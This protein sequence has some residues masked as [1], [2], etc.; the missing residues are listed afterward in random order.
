M[1]RTLSVV[2]QLN[3]PLSHLVPGRRNPRRVKPARE[4]HRQLVALIRSQGL[5]QPLVVR[6]MED[7]PKYYLVIAGHRRLAALKEIHQGDRDPKIACVLRDVDAD[8]ADALSLG[9]NFGHQGMHPLDEAEAFA[10][11][12]TR[13]GKDAEAIAAE[14]GVSGNYVKQRI[15]LAGLAGV[16]KAAY[17]GN[18]I[19]TA[20]A[21]A[22]A[23]VPEDR[24][25]EVWK[26]LNGH[27]RHA[28]H[29]RNIIAHGWIDA[30]HAL[31]DVSTLPDSAVSRDLFGDKVLIERGAFM[32]AQ[33]EALASERDK[34]VED[35]WKEVFIGDYNELRDR[36]L[37]MDRPEREFDE[38]TT[39]QLAKI[40]ARH[41]KLEIEAEKID[42]ND[43]ARQQ[44]IQQRFIAL[45]AK[46]QK[47]MENA[48]A[49]VSEET[50]AVATAFLIL[51]PDGKV[52]REHRL[53]RVRQ[54]SRHSNEHAGDGETGDGD[55]VTGENG[56][57]QPKPPTSDDLADRQLAATFTH[58]VIAVREA[59]LG[60]DKARRRVLALMLH[61]KVR[62]EALAIR[63]E[64]NGT[65][66]HATG[67]ESFASATFDRLAKQRSKFDPF[68]EDSSVD[69]GAAYAR[70]GELSP[71]K[72]DSL[73]DLLIVDSLTAHMQRRTELVHLLA[74]ELKVNIRDHWRPD[75]AWLSGYQKIQLSH[76]LAELRGPVYSPAHENR[77]KSELVEALALLFADAAE[78]RLEDKQLAG[79]VNGWIPANLREPSAIA[80]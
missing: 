16:V 36:M 80:A 61:E 42:P 68:K 74:T 78:G 76:L 27:P 22:F 3:V 55:N 67:G 58:Q 77:K 73:I 57:V 6:P 46:E 11:L 26:E 9:E 51:Q 1:N 32:D 79:R 69:D 15:K 33:L 21:A 2:S 35:G 62:S 63:H 53:P 20:T 17:R 64:S 4:A 54:G 5:L 59:L 13:D 10:S 48:P 24:Q 47:M 14:F 12:A 40:E 34:L 37:S 44:R 75:S 60:D 30:G 43:E 45:E 38:A 71:S 28:E 56:A 19:D 31:F 23:A 29:V 41:R 66:L 65:T 39:R 72:L 70:L 8:T 7:K 18:E 52:Q 49:F 50:K 25:N